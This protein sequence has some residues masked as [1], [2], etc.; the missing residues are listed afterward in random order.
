MFV[1][2][3]DINPLKSIRYQYVTIGIIILNIAV[4][5]IFQLRDLLQ[6]NECHALAFSKTF[7]IIPLELEG[8]QV[9]LPGECL[10]TVPGGLTIPEPFTLISYMFL[11]GDFWH[12]FGNMLFLWVFGD[13]VE[14]DLG[15]V[16][17]VIFYLLCGIAGGLLHSLINPGST[18]PL[19]GASGAIA[20]IIAA[21]LILHPRVHVWVLFLRVIPLQIRAIYVLGIWILMNLYFALVP[22]EPLVAWWAHVGG[23]IAGALLVLVLRRPGVKLFDGSTVDG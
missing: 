3:R 17:Y 5:V 10:S 15:H 19:I 20:G 1:P 11:H 4:F 8:T 7:G 16:R 21:Y 14:D 23:M 13:N 22:Q 18:I 12:L 6:G 9:E 2:V